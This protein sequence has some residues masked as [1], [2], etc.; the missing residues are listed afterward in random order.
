MPETA[1][2]QNPTEA[3]ATPVTPPPGETAPAT[4]PAQTTPPATPAVET[5]PPAAPA[6]YE[7]RAPEGKEY[8]SQLIGAYSEGAKKAGLTQE[9]AQQLLET[10]APILATRQQEQITAVQQGWIEAAKSDK[11][12]GGDKFQENLGVAKKALEQFGSPELRTLLDQT[13][14]GSH[15]EVIRLLV[16]AGKALAE[17]DRHV[18][19]SPPSSGGVSDAKSFYDNS[20]MS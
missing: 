11:E 4:P 20:K 15:P 9:K 3:N 17:D 19:G 7:F 8:D 13:S 5:P 14:L 18:T 16:K 10:M 6:T 1:T 12:F 2:A